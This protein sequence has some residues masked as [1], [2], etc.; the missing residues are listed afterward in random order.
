MT[1]RASRV[2]SG[3]IIVAAPLALAAPAV[4]QTAAQTAPQIEGQSDQQAVEHNDQREPMRY[5]VGLGPNIYPKFPGS[6]GYDIGPLVDFSRAR[7]DN[8]FAFEAPDESFDVTLLN[9]D[10][11]KIG[12]S[13]N[14]EGSRT[15]ADVGADL[16]KVGFTV[17]V[18][19]FAQIPLGE[20][21]RFR[22]ELRKGLGGHGGWISNNS[23]DLVF[24]DG[25]DWLV[26]VGPRVAWADGEYHESWYGVDAAASVTSG[27]P[28]FEADGGIMSYG[29]T[30]SF[31]KQLSTRVGVFGYGKYDRLTGDAA[32]SPI[33]SQLGSRDQWSGGIALSYTFGRGVR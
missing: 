3:L 6:D 10:G 22:S 9:L 30:A 15:A 2:L 13:A 23:V 17:E 32:S 26:S 28:V 11:F 29:A 19:A 20:H 8:E 25:D 7:G 27:L 4:A 18:G 1:H 31:I 5:R 14:L 16:P 21:L 33:V 12:P 24:R